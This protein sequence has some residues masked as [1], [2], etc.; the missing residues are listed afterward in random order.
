MFCAIIREYSISSRELSQ[1]H[2]FQLTNTVS[3]TISK[4]QIRILGPCLFVLFRETLRVE[5]LGIREVLW[6]HLDTQ[7]RNVYPCPCAEC[8][9]PFSRRTR[10]LVVFEAYPV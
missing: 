8:D 9:A 6:I 7:Q 1:L 5:S 4:R 2:C 10:K 3:G